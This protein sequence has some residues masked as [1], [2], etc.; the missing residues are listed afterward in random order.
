MTPYQKSG[1]P[2]NRCVFTYN[3]AKFY[4]YLIRKDGGIRIFGDEQA[5]QDVLRS[6]PDPN[7]IV[8]MKSDIILAV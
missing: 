1:L 7:N 3:L 5:Q 6:V 2:V 8:K 4:P